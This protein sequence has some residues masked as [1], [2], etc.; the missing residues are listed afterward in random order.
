MIKSI[1]KRT[2]LYQALRFVR[3][4]R[5]AR[6]WTP[7]DKRMLDFYR[8]YIGP[9]DLC[10]DIGANIGNRTKIFLAL[11]ARVVS[12]EPQ[13]DCASLITAAYGNDQKLIVVNKAVGATHGRAELVISDASPLASLSREWIHAVQNSGRF[14]DYSWSRTQW[15]D[16]ITLDELIAEHGMPR[17]IKIDVE[18]YEYEVLK[19]LTQPVDTLSLE[20]T[21]EFLEQTMMCIKYLKSLGSIELNYSLKESMELCLDKWTNG[22]AIAD[23]LKRFQGDNIMYGD[24]YVRFLRRLVR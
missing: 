10:F 1:L 19:G 5:A 13:R 24:L 6:T 9:G 15:V 18:G 22:D 20:F 16:V 8:Q 7:F 4:K 3:S 23:I 2:P 14:S 11:E 12:V 21:P 17:F